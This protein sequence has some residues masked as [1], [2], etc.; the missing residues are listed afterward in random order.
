MT[1]ATSIDGLADQV[2]TLSGELDA[3]RKRL[4]KIEDLFNEE[5]KA[6][7]DGHESRLDMHAHQIQEL[8][9]GQAQMR[10][11]IGLMKAKVERASDAASVAALSTERMEQLLKKDIEVRHG[12]ATALQG[13]LDRIVEFIQPR[14]TLPKLEMS[15]VAT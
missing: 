3:Y 15:T 14:V 5:V 9:E 1:A 4:A 2:K 6:E 8:S 7:L 12:H 11:D 10:I 13:T